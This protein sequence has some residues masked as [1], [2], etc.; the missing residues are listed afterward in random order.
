LKG[1]GSVLKITYDQEADVLYIRLN[2]RAGVYGSRT[3]LPWTLSLGRQVDLEVLGAS[4][5]FEK[6]GFPKIEKPDWIPR[7]S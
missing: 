4:R 7:T 6:R 1:K 5:L 2:T 3:I